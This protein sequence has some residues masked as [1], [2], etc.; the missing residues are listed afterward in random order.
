V[1]ETRVG[2]KQIEGCDFIQLD[3]AEAMKAQP[4]TA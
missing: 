1:F 2:D 4:P 3:E